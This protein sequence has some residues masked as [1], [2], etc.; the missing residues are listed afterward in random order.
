MLGA[1]PPPAASPAR[2]ARAARWARG[3]TGVVIFGITAEVLGLT[4]VIPTSVLPLT[5]TVLGHAVQ[6]LG[7]GRFLAD[8]GA[9]VAAW[10][11]GLALTVVIGSRSASCSAA[12]R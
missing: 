8:L 6:L 2:K 1:T 10:A 3:L 11:V 12:C 5:S 4:G 9:T 7:S